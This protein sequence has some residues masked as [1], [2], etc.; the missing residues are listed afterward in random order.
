MDADQFCLCELH[1]SWKDWRNGCELAFTA[2][3]Y[4]CSEFIVSHRQLLVKECFPLLLKITLGA[5]IT[6]R[7]LFVW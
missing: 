1:N 6:G 3:A 7:I 4:P 5:E 2:N